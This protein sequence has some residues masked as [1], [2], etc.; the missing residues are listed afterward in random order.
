M[1]TDLRWTVR[2]LQL[3]TNGDKVGADE[4]FQCS[5]T[6]I[7]IITLCEVWFEAA[8]AAGSE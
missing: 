2:I 6:V 4:R 1:R 5:V 8:V 7:P 3:S